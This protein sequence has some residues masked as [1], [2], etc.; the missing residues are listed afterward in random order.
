MSLPRGVRGVCAPQHETPK[1]AGLGEGQVGNWNRAERWTIWGEGCSVSFHV[2]S[3]ECGPR[4]V[5]FP[6]CSSRAGHAVRA[7]QRISRQRDR[8]DGEAPGRLSQ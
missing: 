2:P 6:S 8:M 7:Q 5:S 1:S 3:L 4:T